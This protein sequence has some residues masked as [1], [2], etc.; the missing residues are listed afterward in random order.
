MRILAYLILL[1]A[2]PSIA[3]AQCAP[4]SFGIIHN[5]LVQSEQTIMLGINRAGNLNTGDGCGTAATNSQNQTLMAD[6]RT[7]ISGVN[8][9]SVGI[10]YDLEGA[11]K[12]DSKGVVIGIYP[13]GWYDSTSQGGQ[14]ES[15]SAGALDNTGLEALASVSQQIG[16][17]TATSKTTM[18][19]KSFTVD[20][21]SVQSVATINDRSGIPMLQVSHIYGPT[22]GATNKTLFQVLVTMTN[23]SVG[24]LRDVRYCRTMDWD[25]IESSLLSDYGLGCH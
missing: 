13:Q 19:V 18:T 23:I 16:S 11:P 20:T 17:G 8:A 9:G 22:T 21:T 3:N 12:K 1:L 2:L 6:K 24:T 15:W 10:S 5:S 4:G 14:W 25:V 7:K